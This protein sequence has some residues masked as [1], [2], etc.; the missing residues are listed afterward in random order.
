[1][2]QYIEKESPAIS[3]SLAKVRITPHL[4]KDVHAFKASLQM[5]TRQ[6]IQHLAKF[7]DTNAKS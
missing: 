7:K 3:A 1:M 5:L 6:V 2:K 4:I